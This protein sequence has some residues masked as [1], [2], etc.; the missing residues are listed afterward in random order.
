MQAARKAAEEAARKAAEEE[1]RV[2]AEKAAAEEKA[3]AEVLPSCVSCDMF[4]HAIV[5]A[6][7]LSMCMWAYATVS[8]CTCVFVSE[9]VCKC[10][11][12]CMCVP[13]QRLTG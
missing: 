7:C 10:A 5:G 8:V 11:Y 6:F 2:A 1:T 9:I 12:V 3:R 13:S 4:H